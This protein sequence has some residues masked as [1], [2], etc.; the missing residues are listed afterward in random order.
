VSKLPVYNPE[1][2]L[3]PK[4]VHKHRARRA[5]KSGK[6][7]IAAEGIKSL[8]EAKAVIVQLVAIIEDKLGKL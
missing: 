7:A 1:D 6:L 8:P 5:L 4:A 2:T 3:S